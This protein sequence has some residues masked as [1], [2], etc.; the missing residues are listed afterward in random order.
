MQLDLQHQLLR[1]EF[2][3]VVARFST[4]ELGLSCNKS[5]CSRLRKCCVATSSTMGFFALLLLPLAGGPKMEIK[6][7]KRFDVDSRLISSASFHTSSDNC[8]RNTQK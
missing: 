7:G 5:G 1:N 6:D 2:N 8:E 3:S 4:H